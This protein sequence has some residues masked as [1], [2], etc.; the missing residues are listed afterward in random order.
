[1]NVIFGHVDGIDMFVGCV[2]DFDMSQ[3]RVE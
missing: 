3:E 1:M 2:D